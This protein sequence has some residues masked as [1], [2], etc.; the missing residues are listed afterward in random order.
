MTL[1][2]LK[3][4]YYYWRRRV[5]P[6]PWSAM[7]LSFDLNLNPLNPWLK[8]TLWVNEAAT[9]PA[10]VNGVIVWRVRWLWLQIAYSRWL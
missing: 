8:P 4:G 7:R 1:Q 5:I 2:Q 6:Y 10:R 9:E 3:R